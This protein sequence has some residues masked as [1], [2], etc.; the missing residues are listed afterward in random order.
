MKKINSGNFFT[1]V[2]LGLK[3]K[4]TNAV[5]LS[6]GCSGTYNIFD[7]HTKEPTEGARRAMVQNL[8]PFVRPPRLARATVGEPILIEDVW[9]LVPPDEENIDAFLNNYFLATIAQLLPPEE[10][11]EFR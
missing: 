8:V 3:R 6:I 1:R 7:P 2:L 11:G 10:R 5:V 4:N 9:R